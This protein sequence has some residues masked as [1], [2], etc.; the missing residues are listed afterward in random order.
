MLVSSIGLLV[1]FKYVSLPK[2][3]WNRSLKMGFPSIF[4]LTVYFFL[5]LSK[6]AILSKSSLLIY[7]PNQKG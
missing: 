3:L 2:K 6:V 5:V 4:S 7:L 1:Y